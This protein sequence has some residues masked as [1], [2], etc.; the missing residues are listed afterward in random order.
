MKVP[1]YVERLLK[2]IVYAG[3]DLQD[4]SCYGYTYKL[5]LSNNSLRWDIFEGNAEKLCKW[6]ERLGAESKIIG[7][8]FYTI[9]EHRKP[10]YK[11]D[12]VL[13]IMTDPI[14]NE[15]EKMGLLKK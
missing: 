6:A 4:T 10:Y 14:A 11:K 12:Y 15:L 13:F 7:R 9:K 3:T 5:Q 2:D 8:K 1:K